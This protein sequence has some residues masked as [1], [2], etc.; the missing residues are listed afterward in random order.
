MYEIDYSPK[1]LHITIRNSEKKIIDTSL[2]KQGDIEYNGLIYN[3]HEIYTNFHAISLFNKFFNIKNK[4]ELVPTI[5][6]QGPVELVKCFHKE[7]DVIFN[8]T[9]GGIIAPF[10]V[11]EEQAK[12]MLDKLKNTP[13]L[14]FHSAEKDRFSSRTITTAENTK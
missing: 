11:A 4:Y 2:T 12:E 6:E 10:S 13:E 8:D 9:V 7:F 3:P 5:T 14:Y 1:I